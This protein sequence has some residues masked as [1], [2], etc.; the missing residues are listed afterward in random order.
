[1][2]EQAAAARVARADQLRGG[3]S[4]GS[5]AGGDPAMAHLLGSCCGRLS[6]ASIIASAR[7]VRVQNAMEME[8]TAG[9]SQ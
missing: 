2:E 1:M 3:G 6:T 7:P 5:A 8:L 4:S 9:V